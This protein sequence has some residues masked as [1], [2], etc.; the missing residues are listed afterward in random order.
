[1]DQHKL[2][3]RLLAAPDKA[4]SVQL[5]FDYMKSHGAAHYEEEVT[6]MQHALQAAYLAKQGGHEPALV[7]AALFHDIGHIL[8]DDPREAN[9]PTL[10]NDLHED[11]AADY[12]H[13]LFPESVLQAIRLHVAAKRYLCTVKEGYYDKL[14]EASQK[15]YHLQGGRMTPDEVAD[16]EAH[17]YYKEA[18]LLRAW[19]DRAKDVE[20]AV[21]EIETYEKDVIAAMV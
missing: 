20:K 7:T 21:P 11:I 8:A 5:L 16:F 9:N 12:L 17:D 15:S 1:M 13:G 18:V 2:K 10:K 6:Q 14:S 3:D 4:R 19:D